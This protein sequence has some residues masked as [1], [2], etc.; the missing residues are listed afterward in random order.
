MSKENPLWTLFTAGPGQGV[1]K[2]NGGGEVLTYFYTFFSK[3]HKE[4]ILIVEN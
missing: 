1:E 2:G 3:Q 4:P